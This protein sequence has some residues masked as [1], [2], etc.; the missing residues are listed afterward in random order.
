MNK[1]LLWQMEIIPHA[2]WEM[3]LGPSLSWDGI[4]S[5]HITVVMA[6]PRIHPE[7]SNSSLHRGVGLWD[8]SMGQLIKNTPLIAMRRCT[9]TYWFVLLCWG[10]PWASRWQCLRQ[11]VLF[12]AWNIYQMYLWT[13]C[14]PPSFSLHQRH[15]WYE[16]FNILGRRLHE[17][18]TNVCCYVR[19][20]LR[21][22]Q[23]NVS[24]NPLWIVL[25]IYTK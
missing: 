25:E 17:K 23:D 5:D 3:P 10:K 20:D 7:M 9:Q 1:A 12:C 14:E 22:T 6:T 16:N 8:I 24:S 18:L 4:I 13:L 2:N 21:Q 11:S 19:I 15:Y